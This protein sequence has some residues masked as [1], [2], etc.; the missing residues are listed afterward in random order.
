MVTW[1]IHYQKVGIFWS[2]CALKCLLEETIQPRLPPG[3]A[4]LFPAQA[5]QWQSWEVMSTMTDGL[6]GRIIP[7]PFG[8]TSAAL[9]CAAGP[10][11]C[12]G[13]GVKSIT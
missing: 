7:P 1:G 3:L 5:R 4:C 8:V 6:V 13:L 11:G 12:P 10:G 9:P 2:Y